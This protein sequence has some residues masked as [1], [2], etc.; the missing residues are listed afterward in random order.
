MESRVSQ[1]LQQKVLAAIDPGEV[2]GL[3]AKL[4]QFPSV[5]P[6]GEEKAIAEFLADYMQQRGLEA[7]LEESLPGRPSALGTLAG[8]AGKPTLIFNG[9]IDVVPATEGWSFDPFAGILKDGRVYGRGSADM[10]GGVAA[11][12]T[13]A[14]V[15]RRAGVP[16]RGTLK[17]LC[18]ADEESGEAGTRTALARGLRGDFAIVPEPTS[19]QPVIAHK[20][21][22]HFAVTTRGVTAH[23]STPELGLNAIEKMCEVVS[24]LDN[25][26]GDL[27]T[28]THRLV[29]PATINIGTI[30]GGVKTN[31]VPDYCRM[32]VDRRILPG[33]TVAE[34]KREMEAVIEKARQKDAD[35]QVQLAVEVETAP[36]E[37]ADNEPV[38]E[39]LQRVG[40]QVL[41]RAVPIGSWPATS[42]AGVMVSRGGIPTVIFGPGDIN[43]AHKPDEWV[44]LGEVVQ[45]TR[46]FALTIVDL[47]T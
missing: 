31:V 11:M 27:A 20:G 32:T 28:K 14:A 23:G 44:D 37:I 3:L 40:R 1:E 24:A 38:V 41:G 36:M 18:A 6:P 12:V 19:L 42:D 35:L 47:L 7:E 4:V 2:A 29:G 43:M 10:K 9:H 13:A 5:N 45:A 39:A 30:T 8:S 22:I 25:Y 33:E 15:V 16:L 46:I 21:V 26:K 34:A 17:L